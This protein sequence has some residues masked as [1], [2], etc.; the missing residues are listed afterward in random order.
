MNILISCESDLLAVGDNITLR[1]TLTLSIHGAGG[2]YPL[3]YS[4][5]PN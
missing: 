4:Y 1:T 5:Y 2:G 3:F